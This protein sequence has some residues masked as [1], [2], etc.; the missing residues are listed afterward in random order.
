M[1]CL[2]PPDCVF[3]AHFH[4]DVQWEEGGSLDDM[5]SCDAYDEIPW[6][7]FS[8]DVDHRHPADNDRG[9]RFALDP[10]KAEDFKEVEELRHELGAI[11]ADA[12]ADP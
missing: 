2:L 8:G 5:P 6:E 7:I 11:G 9:L 4:E 1:V 3:C 10:A 12:E